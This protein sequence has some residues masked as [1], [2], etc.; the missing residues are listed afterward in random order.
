MVGSF[1]TGLMGIELEVHPPTEALVLGHHVDHFLTT[2]P[3]LTGK[4]AWAELEHVS[5]RTNDI[6]VRHD[7]TKKTT[8]TN[9]HGPSFLWKARFPGTYETLLINRE[10]VKATED[11]LFSGGPKISGVK[12]TMGAG[13]KM[14]VEAP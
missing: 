14:T 5:V 4:T 9:N 2:L 10:P 1:V 12:I 13:E 3:Q 11:E 7:G 8:V 6:S